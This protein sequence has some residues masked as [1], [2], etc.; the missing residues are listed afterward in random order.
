MFG[1]LLKNLKIPNML[2]CNPANK[3]SFNRLISYRDLI[4]VYER[5]EEMKAVT[6]SENSVLQ[7]CFGVFKHFEWVIKP[8]GSKVFSNKGGRACLG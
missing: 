2:A 1:T 3:L 6:M 5:H 4:I 8:F 7:S